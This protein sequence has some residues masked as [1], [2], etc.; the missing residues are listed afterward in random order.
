MIRA[1]GTG[2]LCPELE[3]DLNRSAGR[4]VSLEKM[5]KMVLSPVE[6]HGLFAKM[7]DR[8]P[9]PVGGALCAKGGRA[10]HPRPYCC[11]AV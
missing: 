7:S 10:V 2:K 5:D 6:V 4:G 9:L 3:H 8:K 11:Q 1:V